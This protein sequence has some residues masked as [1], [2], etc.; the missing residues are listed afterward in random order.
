MQP[1]AGDDSVR[2]LSREGELSLLLK[3]IDIETRY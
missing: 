2:V 1:A 3:E